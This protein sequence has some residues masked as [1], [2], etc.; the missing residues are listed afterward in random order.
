M[1]NNNALTDVLT[2]LLYVVHNK[3]QVFKRNTAEDLEKKFYSHTLRV[4]T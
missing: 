3:N 2:N 4:N 1:K